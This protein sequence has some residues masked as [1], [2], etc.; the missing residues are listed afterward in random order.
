MDT[1]DYSGTITSKL[2]PIVTMLTEAIFKDFADYKVVTSEQLGKDVY[3]WLMGLESE[4]TN[5]SDRVFANM[6]T[7][8]VR[9]NKGWVTVLTNRLLKHLAEK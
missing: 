5:D 3:T 7:H 2:K 4:M 1:D 9:K 8:M 6:T